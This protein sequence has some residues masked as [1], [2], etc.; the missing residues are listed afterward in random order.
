MTEKTY[1]EVIDETMAMCTD[2]LFKKK[3][4]YATAQDY[5]HNFNVAAELEGITPRQRRIFAGKNLKRSRK[6]LF[7][8]QTNAANY[9]K[10]RG[11]KNMITKDIIF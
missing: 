2:V 1:K 3:G 8:V 9:G 7:C 5:F 4:E 10:S 11:I 6:M